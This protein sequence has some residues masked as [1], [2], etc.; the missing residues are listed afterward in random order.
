MR[1]RTRA[2]LRGAAWLVLGGCLGLAGCGDAAQR[3]PV[4]G[5]VTVGGEPLTRGLLR[6]HPAGG[7]DSPAGA[8]PIAKINPDG[9]YQALTDGKPGVPVGRY[10]VTW[11]PGMP[12]PQNFA[13]K[14][15]QPDADLVNPSYTDPS[16]TTLVIAVVE[17][18][19]PGAYDLKLTP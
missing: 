13:A 10:K 8:V 4:A 1:A 16:Q 15:L 5:K 12:S 11:A 2:T 9:T 19:S 3:L 17:N 18:A 14:K 6:F 7:S